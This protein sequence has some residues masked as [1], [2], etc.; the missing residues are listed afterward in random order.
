[1]FRWWT[2]L[3]LIGFGILDV[4]R[5][6]PY[7]A[8]LTCFTVGTASFSFA[9]GFAIPRSEYYGLPCF[10]VTTGLSVAGTF[11]ANSYTITSAAKLFL[12]FLSPQIGMTVGLFTIETYFHTYQSSNNM[13][14]HIDFPNKNLP[15]LLAVNAMIIM[16]GIAYGLIAWGMP[17]DWIF[18]S[19]NESVREKADEIE[20]PC[21]NEDKE[22]GVV[23]SEA[24]LLKVK[25]LTH[26]YPDGTN[27]V[28]NISFS[29]KQGEV[30]SFL[31]ANG[32]G[33]SR[34]YRTQWFAVHVTN[35]IF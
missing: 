4:A 16:S 17:F 30:L 22:S 28:K 8:L 5:I 25:S 12:C 3:L 34:V 32:A 6:I 19:E 33:M 21:D 7:S 14:F 10:L 13:P 9:F 24:S 11:V 29:V 31:G 27:A 18:K 35:I 2:I 26:V 15:S 23:D 1:M 20:Y